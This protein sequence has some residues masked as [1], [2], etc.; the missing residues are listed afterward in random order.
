M[1]TKL[2]PLQ[3]LQTFS[4]VASSGSFTSAAKELNLSQSAV[5]RQVQQLEHF[6]GKPL[7]QRNS[8][9]LVLTDQGTMLL[10][11][12]E[13][14]IS[15]FMSSLEA[16][17]TQVTNINIRMAP[18]IARR[19]FF[20]LLRNL[21]ESLPDLNIN[22]DTA[23]YLEPQ[24]ALGNLD[25][26]IVYG[27]GRWPG[28]EV[29]PIQQEIITPVCSPDFELLHEG[30]L[31]FDSLAH[32]V[33]LH[34][35]PSHSDWQ[36]WLQS[37]GLYDFKPYKHQTFDTQDFALTLAA[38][39]HGVAIGD[40]NIIKQDLKKGSLILPFEQSIETGYGYYAI[41]PSRPASILKVTP[42]IE[43][44][45]Q[46]CAKLENAELDFDSSYSV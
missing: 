12:I 43:W 29:V 33:L 5:S 45:K 3:T 18:T 6:F 42:F 28:M 37:Q 8:R 13:H 41:Y 23:W 11:L 24:F 2:P 15:S 38:N 9:N 26:M 25:I 46:V 32:S 4:V 22:V 36:L 1:A 16:T 40:L 39:G 17:M 27:N 7:F 34:S 10:P 30:K 35:N 14:T 21:N 19:W 44:L 31:T 20:P